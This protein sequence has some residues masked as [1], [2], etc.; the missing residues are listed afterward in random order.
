MGGWF[1]TDDF[2]TPKKFRISDGTT[3]DPLGYLVL[4]EGDFNP[5]NLGFA[6]SSAGDEAWL[7][8]GDANTNLTGYF[9]G[10]SFG[11]ADNGI[12]FG[13]YIT[14]DG[15]E[16]FV[17]QTALTLGKLNSGPRVGPVVISEVMYH[18]PD[19]ADGSN[20]SSDEF[21]E[22]LNITTNAVALF[23]PLVPGNAWKITGG[24]DFTFPT[25]T[26]LNAR[27][28]L[29]V[30]NFDPTN[31]AF[32]DAFRTTHGI[33]PGVPL[34][35]PFNG[36]LD[37]SGDNV[38]LKKPT[39][40]LAGVVP[41]VL[42]DKLSFKDSPPWPLG[43]DGLGLSLQRRDTFAYGN[44]PANWVAAPPTPGWLKEDLDMDW[45]G[46]GMLN[47]QEY[48]A[49]TDP[50]DPSSSLTLDQITVAGAGASLTF[51]AAANRTYTVQYT[52]SLSPMNW[53]KLMDVSG[54][55]NGMTAQIP[56]QSTNTTRYY[57]VV[58]PAQP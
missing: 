12:S 32:A 25:N 30:V 54:G 14:S 17:A 5:G 15:E 41:Y 37:N 44:D 21:I 20:N 22:V 36:H 38:E 53:Q 52:D 28:T 33:S 6:F 35:G 39:T 48:L 16:H 8:S 23:D 50:H 11:A 13:R 26:S 19:F 42:V 9:H 43:A 49:G 4:S 51:Q 3:I 58:T 1:L 56:D 57:R 55:A 24:I 29:L 40:P 45:D 10:T 27:E 7:F 18:P 47:W 2:N 34:Y 46:D 31:T